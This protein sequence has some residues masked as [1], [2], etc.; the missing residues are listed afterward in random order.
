MAQVAM[1]YGTT[2]PTIADQL[3]AQGYEIDNAD[4]YELSREAILRLSFTHVLTDAMTDKCFKRLHNEIMKYS[5]EIKS[6]ET[7]AV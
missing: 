5:R 2:A 6:S 7:N 1:N 4:R 3:K